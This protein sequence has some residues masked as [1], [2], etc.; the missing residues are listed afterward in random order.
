MPRL[1]TQDSG[2]RLADSDSS[3][4]EDLGESGIGPREPRSGAVSV[5]SFWGLWYFC[6]RVTSVLTP[7][8]PHPR[9]QKKRGKKEKE[10]LRQQLQEASGKW[11]VASGKEQQI[12]KECGNNFGKTEWSRCRSCGFRMSASVLSCFCFCFCYGLLS[13]CLGVSSV[14][15]WVSG[16]WKHPAST[17]GRGFY[18]RTCQK[19]QCFYAITCTLYWHFFVGPV[20]VNTICCNFISKWFRIVYIL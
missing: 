1:R 4:S 18:L 8:P 15:V 5:V 10:N 20:R 9:S 14:C 17:T 11:L 7:L 6:G 3:D 12:R 16:Q 2:L 19:V 13:S